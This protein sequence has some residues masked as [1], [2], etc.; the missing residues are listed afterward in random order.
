M[1]SRTEEPLGIISEWEQLYRAENPRLWRALLACYGD[2]DVAS[3]AVAEA[4]AQAIGTASAIRDRSAWVWKA[5]FRIAAGELQRR[6]RLSQLEDRY[7][8]EMTDPD[9]PRLIEAL[10]RLTP[11]QR[12]VIVMHD[13]ADRPTAEI[14]EVLKMKPPTIHVHLSEGRKRLRRYLEG[15]DV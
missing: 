3:D 12:V 15:T 1:T 10:R 6:G 11:S 7:S 8:Y 13:Y 4:F 5:S 14:A 9:L 2:P